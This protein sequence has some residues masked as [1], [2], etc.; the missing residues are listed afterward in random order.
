MARVTALPVLGNAIAHVLVSQ[1]LK[2][3]QWPFPPKKNRARLEYI[4]LSNFFKSFIPEGLQGFF[5]HNTILLVQ[6]VKRQSTV[7]AHGHS[8]QQSGA[9][10]VEHTL[11]RTWQSCNMH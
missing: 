5:Q 2:N 9:R 3:L 8:M 1:C 7:R 4:E 10:G 11:G 6:P